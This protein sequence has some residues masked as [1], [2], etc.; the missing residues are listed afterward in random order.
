MQAEAEKRQA[1]ARAHEDRELEALREL[2]D[3]AREEAEQLRQELKEARTQYE[4]LLAQHRSLQARSDTSAAEAQGQLRVKAFETERLQAIR[5]EQQESLQ[6]LRAENEKL[7][8]KCNHLESEYHKLESSSSRKAADL[9]S[10]LAQTA[11]RLGEYQEMERDLDVDAKEYGD[12][13]ACNHLPTS[14]RH[15]LQHA[16]E[17]AQKVSQLQDALSEEQQRRQSAEQQRKR[18]E[19]EASRLRE[20]GQMA[21]QPLEYLVEKVQRAESE[22]SRLREEAQN[23]RAE[24][25]S[26]VSD[27]QQLIQQR[28]SLAKVEEHFKKKSFKASANGGAR[29]RRKG[30]ERAAR[31]KAITNS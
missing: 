6:E 31:V 22:A 29:Q 4:E 19:T 13:A 11:S 8:K 21:H 26:A 15:R 28:Q 20:Q 2:R 1:D 17:L 5:A 27:L 18:L 30:Q 3:A 14:M 25:D 23:A 9:E 24:R 16:R 12:E 10:E 7:R